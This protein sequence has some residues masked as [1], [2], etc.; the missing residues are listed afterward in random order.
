MEIKEL[1]LK[2]IILPSNVLMAPM[3]GYTSFPFRILMRELG[4]GLCF[5]EMVNSNALKYNDRATKKLLFTNSMEKIKAAQLIGSDPKIMGEIAQSDYLR[6]YDIIDINMG[7]PVPNIFK[8]GAGSALLSDLKRASK[9]IKEC[10]KSGKIITVK[11]RVGLKEDNL[12]AAE[13][14][15]MCE[16]SGADM[17]TIHGRTRNM[18]YSGTPFYDEIEKAKSVVK[19]P[20]IANGGIN[21]VEDAENVMKKT[22]ADGIMIARYALFNPFIF[23]QL[24]N[25]E[26]KKDKYAIMLNQLDLASL[27]Y[28]E[29]FTI[30]YIK[31][32]SSHFM[33]GLKGVKKYKEDLYR[34]GNVLELR[35]VIK[36]IFYK[37]EDHDN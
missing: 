9:I 25:K 18:M 29:T 7:C 8:S 17:I 16:D 31:R 14:A 20:V 21:S 27:H 24:T 22:S 32:L 5:N 12:I 37:E 1:R 26:I 19:I 28:D 36:K 15:K 23:S 33:R 34:C 30:F 35:E 2:N 13:F 4:A 3:A 6:A 10:R 11:T